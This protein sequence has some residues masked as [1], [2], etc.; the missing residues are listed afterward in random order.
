MAF[1]DPIAELLTKIRNAKDAK[2]VFV[3]VAMSG[4]KIN[5]VKILKDRGFIT[6]FL[7]NEELKKIRIFLRYKGNKP[8]IN[9]ITRV[10]RPSLRKY[11]GYSEIPVR[12]GGLGIN[13]LSTS[14]GI[15]DDEK[16]RQ[17][18]V[19]GELLCYVW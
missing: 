13:I 1:N 6:N 4:V 3:D 8:L 5:I 7:V 18:K 2:H 14:K 12:F 17:L 10:S 9:Q 16:A 19:G 15:I 11:V